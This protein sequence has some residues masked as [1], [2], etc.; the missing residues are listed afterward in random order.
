MGLRDFAR[1]LRPGNDQQLATDL[2]TQARVQRSRSATRAARE[3]QA[4]EDKDRAQDRRGRWYR[5]AR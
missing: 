1:T 3:G 4:W 5:P 2:R